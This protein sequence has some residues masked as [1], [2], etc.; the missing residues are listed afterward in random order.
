MNR[1][2]FLQSLGLSAAAG[3]GYLN[4]VAW[5]APAAASAATP[6]GNRYQN[7]LILVELKG[8]NDGLNT[9]IPYT[10]PLYSSLRP[11]LAIARDQVLQ[12]DER[13]GL[14]P[15]LSPLMSLW[16]GKELA[17]VRGV[18]YPKPN[19]S[20]FR[21]IE[22]WDTASDSETFLETG[23][24]GRAL[25]AVPPPRQFAADGVV[26]GASDMGPLA[27]GAVR[28]I[29][30]AD[31]A[32]F[33]RSAKL[34]QTGA[35]QRN[36]ALRH[37]QAVENEVLHAAGKLNSNYAFKTEFP[38]NPFGNQVRTAAQLVAS[39]AGMAVIRL[40]LTGFDT[41]ANQLGPH[42]NLLKVLAEGMAA[43]KAAL[44]ELN[45]WDTTLIMTYAEFGRRPKEN[46][47]GG[48]DHGTANS[49][50]LMGGKVKGGLYGEAPQLNRLDGEGNLGFAVDF[51]SL[52]ATVIERWWG[53]ASTDVLGGKFAP[54][55]VLRA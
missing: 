37:I 38:K 39:Q 36:A 34:A 48:T 27:G 19:L 14:H 51:R 18:G 49:H 40:T 44:V 23:W 54:L 35:D 11:R 2:H 47:S 21:S 42:A 43:L 13:T 55:G 15:S 46:Q 41:H 8:A 4:G 1:R 33:L 52:Y 53:S 32:Q 3:C 17:V 20:H 24:L 45:R 26:V 16:E 10:D 22:I 29:A 6:A 25:A 5:A 30:L 50:F 28:T 12:L 7:L 31:T 9:V